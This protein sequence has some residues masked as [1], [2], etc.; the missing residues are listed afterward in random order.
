[1]KRLAEALDLARTS[2]SRIGKERALAAAFASVEHEDDIAL[3]TAAR[4]AAGRALP[5][6]DGRSIGAGFS[7]FL[8]VGSAMTGFPES[9]VG[10]CA[11]KTGDLG[12]ALGL[13]AAR[14]EGGARP[15]LTLGEVAALFDALAA[16]GQRATKCQLL[17]DAFAKASPLEVKY[18]SRLLLGSM[19]T[20]AQQG[21]VEGAIA[22]AFSANVAQVRRAIGLVADPGL[23]AVIARDGRLEAVELEIGRPVAWMLATPI[24]TL[25][26]PVDPALF[27][28]ED[29]IDGVRVQAH[30]RERPDGGGDPEVTLFARGMERVTAAFPEVVQA[31]AR[32]TGDVAL[33]GEIVARSEGGRPRPFQ[34]LQPR[35]NKLV[36]SQEQLA[37]TPVTLVAYDLLADGVGSCLGLPWTDRRARLEAFVR[38]VP[39]HPA[40]SLHPYRPAS[41]VT[42]EVAFTEARAKGFEGL[43]LKRVDAPY[44][45]GRRGQ[46]WLKVKRAYATLDVVVTAAEEGHGR[47]AGVLSDYTFAVWKGDTLVNVGKAYSGLTDDEIREMTQRL[48]VLTIE[49]VG[50]VRLVRTEIVLEVAFDGVQPSPRHDSGFALRF[51]RIVRIREDKAAADADRL[52]TVEAL[53]A[54]QVAEGHREQAPAARSSERTRRKKPSR[55]DRQLDLF[56]SPHPDRYPKG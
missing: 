48:S 47:R 52:E 4:F 27:V 28:I 19:R 45:A 26:S 12:E 37:E 31:L 46:A 44:E 36:P 51:P 39:E 38:T 29:K 33:D 49:Q 41:S 22:R 35:L 24:E 8:D 32:A 1:M 55:E 9:I 3:A 14:R 42:M 13:L 54:A 23:C 17:L 11:R 15:G 16:S 10:A 53:F 50:R 18:V 56:A 5:V 7:L 20:G 6:G 2:R 40:L 21:V 34:T 30:R 25:A 43:V